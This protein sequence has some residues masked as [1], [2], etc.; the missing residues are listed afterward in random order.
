MQPVQFRGQD[1]GLQNFAVMNH[2]TFLLTPSSWWPSVALDD[3]QP[4][5]K[6]YRGGRT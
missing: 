1:S 2:K 5:G 3:S 4:P 6:C